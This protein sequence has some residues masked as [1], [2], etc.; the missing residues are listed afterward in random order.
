M[1][2]WGDNVQG[3]TR[4][5][6]TGWASVALDLLRF[7]SSLVVLLFHLGFEP[8]PGYQ[9]VMVFFVLSGFLVGGSVLAS[10]SN[11]RW[12]WGDYLIARLTR[13]C[14]VLFPAL[15]LAGVLVGMAKDSALLPVF[16]KDISGE[17]LLINLSFTQAISERY[18][19]GNR[20]LWSL[21]YEF[22]YYLFFPLMLGVAL[23]AR[24]THKLLCLVLLIAAMAWMSPTLPKFPIWLLGVAPWL[25]LRH[26]RRSDRQP[27]SGWIVGAVTLIWMGVVNAQYL[28]AQT[29]HPGLPQQI[30]FDG[31]TALATAVLVWSVVAHLNEVQ[32]PGWVSSCAKTLAGFSFSLYLIHYPII[33]AFPWIKS[34]VGIEG[35]LRGERAWI[36]ALCVLSAYGF[37]QCTERH[38]P[39]L[40]NLL[41]GL[42][43]ARGH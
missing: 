15:M 34:I 36:A 13:L 14:I 27:I 22:W 11:G 28:H 16:M 19:A 25:W 37:A 26:T 29:N 32:A 17:T 8:M 41:R 33:H 3:F 18:Y 5:H 38:T 39:Q 24:V 40:V 9:A 42:K 23:G 7:V 31:M 12:D 20:P 4:I 2:C 30:V 35:I 21:A 6:P 10:V 43:A 1:T